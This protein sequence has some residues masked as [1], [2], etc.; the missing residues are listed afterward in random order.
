MQTWM[1]ATWYPPAIL[2][3]SMHMKTFTCSYLTMANTMYNHNNGMATYVDNAPTM[4]QNA[5]SSNQMKCECA[6]VCA[7]IQLKRQV[8]AFYAH[9][10]IIESNFVP[11]YTDAHAH[12]H[13]QVGRDTYYPKCASTKIGLSTFW[14]CASSEFF[15]IHF[16]CSSSL[17]HQVLL[18][19]CIIMQFW[20]W[21]RISV[22][23][24][25][26]IVI[27]CICIQSMMQNTHAHY[28]KKGWC[29]LLHILAD[30]RLFY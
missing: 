11:I 9:K 28:S 24:C 2:A 18:R 30:A 4:V 7:S 16:L 13:I 15:F 23:E 12:A 29:L 5:K 10:T 22:E 17:P 14:N 19:T 25:Q 1:H 26:Y 20:Q 8:N 6:I 3:I 27:I 21:P